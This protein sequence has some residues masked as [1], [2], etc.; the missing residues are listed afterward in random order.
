MSGHPRLYR[1]NAT[2]YH[3]AAIP[4]DIKD[5]Y[6]KTEETFSLK[7]KDYRE[8]LRLV[9]IA[10]VDVDKRFE[11]HRRQQTIQSASL[12]PELSD[13]QIKL[14]GEI[15]YYQ[16]LDDDDWERENHWGADEESFVDEDA[17]DGSARPAFEDITDLMFEDHVNALEEA[18][19]LFKAG[20]ARGKLNPAIEGYALEIIQD[21]MGIPLD[22]ESKSV[23][24][25]A[26]EYKKAQ[27]RAIHAIRE[28]AKGEVI[29]TPPDAADRSCQSKYASHAFCGCR[30]MGGRESKV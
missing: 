24:R 26:F 9:R 21:Q 11:A 10:A 12:V 3:R 8:A 18:E 17:D 22:P 20:L 14:V 29:E 1:R 30:E 15:A 2:Y 7:T 23:R 28:R 16:H 6:P 19:T 13:E 4:V 25:A 27:I 5:S